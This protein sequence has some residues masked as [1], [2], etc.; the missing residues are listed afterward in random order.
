LV[1]LSSRCADCHGKEHTF[2]QSLA[3]HEFLVGRI[4]PPPSVAVLETNQDPHA[5]YVIARKMAR[6]DFKRL[7]ADMRVEPGL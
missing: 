4:K 2:L 6:D 1:K 3:V 7:R 5:N